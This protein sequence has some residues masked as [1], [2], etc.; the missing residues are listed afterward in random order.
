MVAE[1][2]INAKCE[3]AQECG[4][5]VYIYL[6]GRQRWTGMMRLIATHHNLANTTKLLWSTFEK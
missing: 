6:E 3:T 4:Q 1:F 2:S 5:W